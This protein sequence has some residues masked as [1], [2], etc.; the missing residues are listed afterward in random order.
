MYHSAN[1]DALARLNRL[2]DLHTASNHFD[3]Q[4]QAPVRSHSSLGFSTGYSDSFG[5]GNNIQSGNSMQQNQGFSTFAS[6][7]MS[8]APSSGAPSPLLYGSMQNRGSQ[9]PL[10]A[11]QSST[12]QND[13]EMFDMISPPNHGGQFVPRSLGEQLH[14]SMPDLTRSNWEPV[15]Q[16]VGGQR[17]RHNSAPDLNYYGEDDDSFGDVELDPIPLEEFTP[18]P[19]SKKTVDVDQF[20]KPISMTLSPNSPSVAVSADLLACLE[21][22]NGSAITDNN[23]FEPLPIASNQARGGDPKLHSRMRQSAFDRLQP[24]LT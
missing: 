14:H 24:P 9:E 13:M 3:R 6:S 7:S 12:A 18:R 20:K 2:G 8:H 17:V 21:K 10:D 16:V 19:S 1:M 4:P 23:P 11:Y 15:Q 22:L 5:G